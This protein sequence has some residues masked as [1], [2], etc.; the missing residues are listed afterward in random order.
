MDKFAL[1][2]DATGTDALTVAADVIVAAAAAAAAAAKAAPVVLAALGTRP[3]LGEKGVL[4]CVFSKVPA[5][6]FY[7]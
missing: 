7:S 5:V 3:P 1:V 2:T 6:T 4:F